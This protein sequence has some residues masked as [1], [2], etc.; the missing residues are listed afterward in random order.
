MKCFYTE[1]HNAPW[2]EGE[3]LGY[4]SLGGHVNA[5]VQP[6]DSAKL[7]A[8]ELQHIEVGDEHPGDRLTRL[9]AAKLKADHDIKAAQDAID[10]KESVKARLKAEAVAMAEADI[11]AKAEAETK[12]VPLGSFPNQSRPIVQGSK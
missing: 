4:A 5:I 8:V 12:P 11:D 2:T 6:K 1:R 9:E 7:V 3:I 10:A